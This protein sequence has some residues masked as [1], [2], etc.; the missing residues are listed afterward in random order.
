MDS[1]FEAFAFDGSGVA[2]FVREDD[3]C[4][5]A[6]AGNVNAEGQ[7]VGL[8]SVDFPGHGFVDIRQPRRIPS[9]PCGN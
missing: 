4:V 2:A 9:D 5:H 6:E 7:R 1:P 8:V 3:R